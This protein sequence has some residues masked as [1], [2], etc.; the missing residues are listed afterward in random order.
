MPAPLT[1][2]PASAL[3]GPSRL[4]V[5]A[6]VPLVAF[7]ALAHL[8]VEGDSASSMTQA[9]VDER[10]AQWIIVAAL[11][12]LP[13]GVAGV[14]FALIAARLGRRTVLPLA[15]AGLALLTAHVAAQ[16]AL[17]W[18]DDSR[19]LADS[20]YYSVA[21]LASLLGWWAIDALAGLTC[22]HL[23]RHTRARKTSLAVGVATI[24]FLLLEVAIYLP[25]LVGGAELHD[26]IGLPP[27]LLPF[28][29]A[30][31]GVKLRRDA[32]AGTSRSERRSENAHA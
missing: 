26:T 6:V 20:T 3:I 21:I 1:T 25:A 10:A 8:T 4:L 23:S 7:M 28:L 24:L 31:L 9:Q 5:L 22:L 13:V 32:T 14:G 11:W 16:A 18:F 17:V 12:V 2:A 19:T 15:A 30:V 29:W 27:M